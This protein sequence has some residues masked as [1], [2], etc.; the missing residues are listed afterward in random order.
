MEYYFWNNLFDKRMGAL[1]LG[2]NRV[3]LGLS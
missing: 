1:A 3:L 2:T